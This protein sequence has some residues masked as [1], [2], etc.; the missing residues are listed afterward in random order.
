MK[1]NQKISR[2][3]KSSLAR[4]STVNLEL[5]DKEREQIALEM[6]NTTSRES[7]AYL[8]CDL[9]VQNPELNDLLFEPVSLF[10]FMIATTDPMRASG[11]LTGQMPKQEDILPVLIRSM[12]DQFNPYLALEF[13]IPAMKKTKVKRDKRALCWAI[14]DMLHCIHK[15]APLYQS[16]FVRTVAAA[17]IGVSTTLQQQAALFLQGEEPYH[18]D[19][20]NLVNDELVTNEWRRLA[21]ILDRHLLSMHGFMSIHALQ[22]FEMVSKPFGLRFHQIIHYPVLA[23]LTKSRIIITP[24]KTEDS[25]QEITDEHRNEILIQLM[26]NDFAGIPP[27]R[28]VKNIVSIVKEAAYGV[29]EKEV[30]HKMLNA[31]SFSSAFLTMSNP[32][33]LHLYQR[34]GEW[35]EQLNPQDEW[36]DIIEMKSAPDNP[37]AYRRYADKLYEKNEREGAY[38]VYQRARALSKESDDHLHTRIRELEEYVTKEYTPDLNKIAVNVDA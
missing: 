31:I 34:S 33:L 19:Y 1:R 3:N 35:A 14:G 15:K 38:F 7:H 27:F 13:L 36:N 4:K 12:S 25:H 37:A 6:R 17:S 2:S 28:F 22:I 18:F 24:D 29:M 23:Y 26:V 30:L 21:E 9:M 8:L 10:L 32:F 5:S 16:L 20:A 11:A